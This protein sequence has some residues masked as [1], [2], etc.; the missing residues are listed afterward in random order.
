MRVA[1]VFVGA[2]LVLVTVLYVVGW[3]RAW[4]HLSYLRSGVSGWDEALWLG[5]TAGVVVAGALVLTTTLGMLRDR[6]PRRSVTWSTLV[7]LAAAGV[8]PAVRAL[9]VPRSALPFLPDPF[10]AHGPAWALYLPFD[11]ALVWRGA[12][13]PFT[14]LALLWACPL[15]VTE[16]ARAGSAR[17]VGAGIAT[18]CV[19]TGAFLH[20]L[21]STATLAAFA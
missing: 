9:T 21:L 20:S 13:L 6:E 7:A 18:L 2:G 12:T 3:T 5:T 8:L 19:L 15:L 16:L 1:R 14:V 10:R 4:N 11:D 17:S